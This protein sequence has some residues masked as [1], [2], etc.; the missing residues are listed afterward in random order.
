[1]PSGPR[2]PTPPFVLAEPTV[3]GFPI[4]K[5][6]IVPPKIALGAFPK[7]TQFFAPMNGGDTGKFPRKEK[8]RTW[9]VAERTLQGIGG[10]VLRFRAWQRGL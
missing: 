4:F 5:K 3:L 8:V 1:M 2:E 7:V 6:A 9:K 10:G